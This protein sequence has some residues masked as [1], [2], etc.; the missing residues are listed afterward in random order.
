MRQW[1]LR[2]TAFAE[3]LIDELEGLDCLNPSS[4]CSETGSAAAKARR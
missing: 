4:F 1:M 3:R 2:I